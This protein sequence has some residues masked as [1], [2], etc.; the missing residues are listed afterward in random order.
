MQPQGAPAVV[1]TTGTDPLLTSVGVALDE[2]PPC[3]TKTV[4]SQLAASQSAAEFIS[5]ELFSAGTKQLDQRGV[6][7]RFLIL[8][9][10]RLRSFYK[11]PDPGLKGSFRFDV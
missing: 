1:T 5:V 6:R 11:N 8:D 3:G 9:D 10:P 7:V 4:T 2:A